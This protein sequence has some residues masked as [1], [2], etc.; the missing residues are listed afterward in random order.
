MKHSLDALKSSQFC[1]QWVFNSSICLPFLRLPCTQ[2]HSITPQNTS[3]DLQ[4]IKK[5]TDREKFLTF[6]WS[7][8]R[9][10]I[11]LAATVLTKLL[12][13]NQLGKNPNIR[14]QKLQ[15]DTAYQEIKKLYFFKCPFLGG[16]KS[17]SYT[18]CEVFSKN[19]SGNDNMLLETVC[20]TK[21]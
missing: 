17:D 1:L 6:I 9:Y 13:T 8:A 20:S 12:C 5:K 3:R 2:L 11:H 7:L 21:Y 18:S 16:G 14:L 15:K 10:N 19:L 4:N